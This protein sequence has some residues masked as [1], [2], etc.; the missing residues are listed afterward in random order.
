M[1]IN[2]LA[3]E[4]VNS[5]TRTVTL[6]L[7]NI[8]I[9]AVIRPGGITPATS[10]RIRGLRGKNAETEAEQVEATN[11][12]LRVMQELIVSWDLTNRGEP[13][14]TTEDGFASLGYDY[15]NILFEGLMEALSDGPK[16]ISSPPSPASKPATR[17]RRR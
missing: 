7:L 1:D 13:V 2:D 9:E 17:S 8:Q 5:L 3:L 4:R 6:P 11:V 14:P 12:I 15:L 16:G 10:T